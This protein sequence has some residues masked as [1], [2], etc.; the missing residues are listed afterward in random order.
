MEVHIWGGR[1]GAQGCCDKTNFFFKKIAKFEIEV[2][3]HLVLSITKF[4]GDL[5]PPCLAKGLYP[6]YS[7]I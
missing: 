3:P 7:R 4:P 2:V 1:G 5:E 6:P